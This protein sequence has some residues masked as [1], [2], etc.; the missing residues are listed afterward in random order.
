MTKYQTTHEWEPREQGLEIYA[1]RLYLTI[2]K[3][4]KI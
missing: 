4:V 3:G 2:Q 1:S